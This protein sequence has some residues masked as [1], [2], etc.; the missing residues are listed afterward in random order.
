MHAIQY[1]LPNKEHEDDPHGYRD[2]LRL[3]AEGFQDHKREHSENNTLGDA[4][5]KRHH[6]N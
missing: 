5:S 3:T 1:H 6:H 4:E 2:M